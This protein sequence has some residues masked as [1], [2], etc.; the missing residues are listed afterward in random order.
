MLNKLHCFILALLLSPCFSLAKET[1]EISEFS[2][3]SIS[4]IYWNS[5]KSIVACDITENVSQPHCQSIPLPVKTH[6]IQNVIQGNFIKSQPASWILETTDS[7][8]LCV[9][10]RK[11]QTYC[12]PLNIPHLDG[13]QLSFQKGIGLSNDAIVLSVQDG[14]LDVYA[15]DLK[16]IAHR[17]VESYIDA[18]RRLYAYL[19]ELTEDGNN[20]VTD[21][22][23]RILTV[24]ITQPAQS[25]I[26]PIEVT[27]DILAENGDR[28]E[29]PIT[30]PDPGCVAMCS[31]A[32]N[33]ACAYCSVL[34]HPAARAACY[35]AAMATYAACLRG[36]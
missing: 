7:Y 2:S 10:T 28:A 8:Q 5:E 15:T 11:N 18:R 19:H 13:S 23:P 14:T 3:S 35:G 27:A 25:N 6:S 17:F 4:K 1:K 32:Y 26:Q 29:N 33:S 30:C 22:Q 36:C 34:P 9:L 31:A 24:I 16:P 20:S 21:R 12:E